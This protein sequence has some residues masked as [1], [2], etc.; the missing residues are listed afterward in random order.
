MA[1]REL[2]EQVK[3]NLNG[4][5]DADLGLHGIALAE[6]ETLEQAKRDEARRLHGKAILDG[7]AAVTRAELLEQERDEALKAAAEYSDHLDRGGT[8]VGPCPHGRT[9]WVRRETCGELNAVQVALL[10][11]D[12]ERGAR[13]RAEAGKATLHEQAVRAGVELRHAYRVKADW[14]LVARAIDMLERATTSAPSGSDVGV[15]A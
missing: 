3:E 10:L 4:V 11:R 6:L 8:L 2:L 13:E 15:I 1:L 5:G 7:S 12:A 14:N 9:P